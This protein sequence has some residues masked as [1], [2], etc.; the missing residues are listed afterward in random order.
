MESS[1]LISIMQVHPDACANCLNLLA[2]G[3]LATNR[4]QLLRLAVQ[5]MVARMQKKILANA[6]RGGQRLWLCLKAI[7]PPLPRAFGVG[8]RS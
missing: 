1:V 4:P 3:V 5:S 8:G 6:L 2:Y 7:S